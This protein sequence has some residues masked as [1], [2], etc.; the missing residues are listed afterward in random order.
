MHATLTSLED[1]EKIAA[2][3]EVQKKF[4]SLSPVFLDSN[5]PYPTIKVLD[6]YFWKLGKKS[7]K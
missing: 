6:L 2:I 3:P 5:K 1:W 4:E 7:N